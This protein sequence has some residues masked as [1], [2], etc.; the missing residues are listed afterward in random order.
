MTEQ[1]SNALGHRQTPY[2]GVRQIQTGNIISS[3]A[4]MHK[5]YCVSTWWATNYALSN[6]SF[7]ERVKQ[8]VVKMKHSPRRVCS[9]RPFYT[10]FRK[11][12]HSHFLSYLRELCVDLNTNCSEYTQGKV[13]S[14][15][16]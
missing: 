5:C 8:T 15:I 4:E 14:V 1:S 12:T 13:D 6:P 16:V 3:R 2:K 11:N 9:V 10:V 7:V